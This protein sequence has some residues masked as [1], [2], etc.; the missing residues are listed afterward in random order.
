MSFANF[1]KRDSAV[2]ASLETRAAIGSGPMPLDLSFELANGDILREMAADWASG[3]R[4]PAE[5]WLERYPHLAAQAATAVQIVYEEVC[6]REEQGEVVDAQAVCQRF[7][8]WRDALEKLFECHQLI[9]PE[10]VAPS[11]PKEGQQLGELQIVARLGRGAA[12]QVFLARQPSLSDR[13]LVVK[14]T[15]RTGDEHLSLARLQHTHI[16]P[17]YHVQDFPDQHLRTLCMPYLGGMSWSALLT[18][19]KR[20]PKWPRSGRSIVDELAAAAAGLPVAPNRS[21]PA[22]DSCRDPATCNRFAGS[23]AAWPTPCTMR[24]SADWYTSTSKPRTC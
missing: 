14:L 2:D 23:A 24:T 10:S 13:P 20:Q 22:S 18:T 1:G 19:L 9:R 7:P 6:L 3:R 4:T 16:V 17:L 15:P 21:G 12:G 11:F 5:R 8:Q